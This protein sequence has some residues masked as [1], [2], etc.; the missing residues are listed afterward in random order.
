MAIMRTY[1]LPIWLL[2]AAFSASATDRAEDETGDVT[3]RYHAYAAGA[4]VGDA[5]ISVAMVGGRYQ[6]VGDARS[7]GVLKSFSKWH[8]RFAARGEVD[9]GG[10]RPQEFYYTERNRRK[11]RDVAV[12]D[13]TLHVTKNGK[14]RPEREA[15]D[16]RDVLSA[17]FVSPHCRDDHHLH[18]GRYIYELQR[19][20]HD[21]ESCRYRV[22]DEDD[23]SFEIDLEL[24]RVNGLVVP[25]RIIVHAWLSGTLEL[26]EPPDIGPAEP[27]LG[28]IRFN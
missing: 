3:L 21:G 22:T 6:V 17:L 19:L 11:V 27:A 23:D 25:G 1:L 2:A 16:G 20:E 15:P 12:R 10:S 8:N 28:K 24:T 14:Q 5:T 9:A 4:L 7:T 26:Q 18:T 13:G